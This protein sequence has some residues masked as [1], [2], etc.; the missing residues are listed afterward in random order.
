MRAKF[1]LACGST[2]EYALI[3]GRDRGRCSGCA[4][5]HYEQLIVGAGSLLETDGR[6]L[7]LR[8]T[9]NPFKNCWGLPAGHVE[10][11]EDPASAAVRETEEETGLRV[12]ANG[13]VDAYFFDDHPKGCG[14]F[15]VYRCEVA[16]GSLAETS[17]GKTPTFFAPEELPHDIA[18]GGHSKAILAWRNRHLAGH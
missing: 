17:E 3:E 11:D 13:L 1:C 8:R 18:G 14:V 7:L 4:R 5:I 9:G 12:E 10:G 16:G 6:L 2:L 15:L